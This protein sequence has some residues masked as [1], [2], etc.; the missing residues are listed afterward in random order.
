MTQHHITGDLNLKKCF[1]K[2]L[3]SQRALWRNH[4]HEYETISS[5][6]FILLH[7]S[8]VSLCLGKAHYSL[9]LQNSYIASSSY[10]ALQ[11]SYFG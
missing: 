1:C 9:F 5:T 2:N 4:I 10:M 7:S 8:T 6:R 3:K 11:V